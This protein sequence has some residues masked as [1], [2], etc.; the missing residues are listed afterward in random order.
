[1]SRTAHDRGDNKILTHCVFC[2]G[3]DL[4]ARSDGSA[5]CHFCNAA[6]TVQSQPQHPGMPQTVD[7]QP[8]AIPDMPEHELAPPEPLPL[9]QDPFN[10]VDLTLHSRRISTQGYLAHLAAKHGRSG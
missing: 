9:S 7:G 5:F 3:G 1:M 10:D 6:F 4:T 8:Y 2:G